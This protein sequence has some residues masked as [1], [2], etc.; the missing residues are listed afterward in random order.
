MAKCKK[1]GTSL[2]F[3]SDKEYCDPC[4][5]KIIHE[6]LEKE[7]QELESIIEEEKHKIQGVIEERKEAVRKRVREG[8]K[9]FLYDYL[10]IPVDSQIDD[11]K[12]TEIFVIDELFELGLD[13]W[14]VMQVI[15]KTMGMSLKNHALQSGLDT[16]AGGIGGIVTGVYVLLKKEAPISEEEAVEETEALLQKFNSRHRESFSDDL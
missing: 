16:Y 9:T 13:G 7:K 5:L 6:E 14:E 4:N 1:C 15:P 10:F 8:K 2:G 3:L 12:T 11:A